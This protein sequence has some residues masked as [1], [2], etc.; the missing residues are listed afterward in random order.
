MKK[1]NKVRKWFL[2]NLEWL[3]LLLTSL[4]CAG[5]L[6]AGH[7]ASDGSVT[8]D[9]SNAQISGATETFI[10]EAKAATIEYAKEA[11]PAVIINDDGEEETIEVPTVESIDGGEILNE[12]NCPEGQECGM[13]AFIYAPTDTYQHFKDYTIGKCWNVDGFA[14]AQCWDLASL[15]SMNYTANKRVFSTCGTGAARGMWICKEQNAG[16]E[17]GLVSDIYKTNVGDIGVWGTGAYG[18]TCVIAGPVKNGYVACLGQNQGG[19]AC[20]G[21]GA[22]TNIINLSINGFL[23]AF[24]PKTY[25]PTP[26]PTPT[27]TPTPT[28]APSPAPHKSGDKIGYTYAK[29]D[30]FSKVLVN[31]GLDGG[32]LWG[33]NGTVVYYTAQ[34]VEQNVLD[35]RGN[36]KIGVPFTLTVR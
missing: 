21:G 9:G 34:L 1:I 7:P 5:F 11:V 8:L 4:V 31:L 24:H 32:R 19:S 18:H 29:G 36:V 6:I 26:A 30:Y 2:R 27:P 25:T 17:Y 10:A 20:P 16:S 13:G 28:P 33:P 12:E 15:H 23:G 3:I 35:S 22:A 14:G